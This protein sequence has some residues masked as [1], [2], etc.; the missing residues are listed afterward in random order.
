MT[1]IHS[2][3][4]DDVAGPF[5]SYAH[6]VEIDGR[7][8]WLFGA[9]QVGV[10]ADGNLGADVTE[11]AQLVWQNISR[12]LASAAMRIPDIV[13]LTMYLVDRGDRAEARRVRDEALGDHRP[14]ST[15]LFVSGL[16]DPAWRIEID[17]VAASPAFG[18][19]RVTASR[20]GTEP[21]PREA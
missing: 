15:L 2:H 5:G 19:E 21:N 3:L 7:A 12:V 8:R 17:F 4:P 18:S 20:P 14:A 13:Q 11:Q 1:R 6:G 9:G 16:S 10:D